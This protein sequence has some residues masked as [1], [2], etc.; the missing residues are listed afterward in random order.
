MSKESPP[1]RDAISVSAHTPSAAHTTSLNPMR[2]RIPKAT[3]REQPFGLCYCTHTQPTSPVLLTRRRPPFAEV[4][5]RTFM[6]MMLSSARSTRRFL[7]SGRVMLLLRLPLLLVRVLMVRLRSAVETGLGNKASKVVLRH[8]FL[9]H[10]L[11]GWKNPGVALP[12]R[13]P[14]ED[15]VRRPTGDSPAG[16]AVPGD[17]DAPC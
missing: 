16:R 12:Q 9:L 1:P 15:S 8:N 5:R 6:L 3:C 7:G 14:G 13:T 2:C 17:V 4:V 10:R 11:R